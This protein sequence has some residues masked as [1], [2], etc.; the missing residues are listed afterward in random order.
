MANEIL[1]VLVDGLRS[2]IGKKDGELIGI[3]PDDLCSIV[4]K[5]LLERN[6]FVSKEDIED[7]VLGCA[8]PEG[9]Q[10]MLLGRAVS[11]LAGIPKESC[12]K[13]VNRFCG[14]SMDSDHL[15]SQSTVNKSLGVRVILTTCP[16]NAAIP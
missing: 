12:A 15:Q 6:D 7:L 2:P 4:V 14:S 16:P 13:V 11:L 8:F 3:L 5:A 9:P 10:G 1:P